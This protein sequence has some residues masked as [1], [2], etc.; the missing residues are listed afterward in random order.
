MN[1]TNLYVNLTDQQED[2]LT[3]LEMAVESGIENC[4]SEGC[5]INDIKDTIES[6]IEKY[7]SEIARLAYRDRIR[8]HNKRIKSLNS[9]VGVKEA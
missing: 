3:K 1:D 2:A 9:V 6:I 4:L 7:E 5:N 8:E